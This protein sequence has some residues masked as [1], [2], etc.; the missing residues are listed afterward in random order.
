MSSVP[1]RKWTRLG[2]SSLTRWCGLSGCTFSEQFNRTADLPARKFYC[3]GG[4]A[5]P[6]IVVHLPWQMMRD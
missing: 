6:V 5:D 3:S 1:T 4:G 2:C